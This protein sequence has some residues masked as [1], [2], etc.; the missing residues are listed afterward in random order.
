[1]G[2]GNIGGA[3]FGASLDSRGDDQAIFIDRD[4]DQTATSTLKDSPGKAITGFLHPN[5]SS[6]SQQNSRGYLQ[7]LLGP[8]N[9]HYLARLA[10]DR[11]GGSQVGADGFTKGLGTAWV[12]IMD[13]V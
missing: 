7:R 9:D 11:P 10:L 12:N 13:F 1:M 8:R 6:R 3:R 5:G 4:W 2:R